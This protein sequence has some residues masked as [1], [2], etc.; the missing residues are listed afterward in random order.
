MPKDMNV[1]ART[2]L[3]RALLDSGMRQQDIAAAVGTDQSNIS[4]WLKGRVPKLDVDD[5]LVELALAR[6]LLPDGHSF[7]TVSSHK[8]SANVAVVGYVGAGAAIVFDHEGDASLGEAPRP[9]GA[10]A[11]T[12]AVRVRGESMPGSAEDGW[13]IYYDSRRD[14]VT[15]DLMGKLCVVGCEDGRVLVKKIYR[16]RGPGLY[17]LAPTIGTIERDVPV[18]WAARVE[19]IRPSNA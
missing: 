1:P 5:A 14:P 13:L 3:L 19:W 8:V 10:P 15:D 17:D 12:V 7:V 16:G 2:Q 9:M 11:T 4:R 18:T 6:G